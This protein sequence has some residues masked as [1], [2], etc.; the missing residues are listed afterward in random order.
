MMER[1]APR[2]GAASLGSIILGTE[3][4]E[5]AEMKAARKLHFHDQVRLPEGCPT[6]VESPRVRMKFGA[7]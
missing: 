2:A 5:E 7:V 1:H 3:L 4:G 6:K